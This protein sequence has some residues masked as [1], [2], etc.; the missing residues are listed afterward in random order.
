VGVVVGWVGAG[1]L[2]GRLDAAVLVRV[3]G[4]SGWPCPGNGNGAGAWVY[5]M[6]PFRA[7]PRRGGGGWVTARFLRAVGCGPR[8]PCRCLAALPTGCGCR[9]RVVAP[10]CWPRPRPRTLES[11]LYA[12]T[13]AGRLAG[14][15]GYVDVRHQVT[16][17]TGKVDR[18]AGFRFG[19]WLGAELLQNQSS[20]EADKRGTHSRTYSNAPCGGIWVSGSRHAEE[21]R[22]PAACGSGN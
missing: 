7:R 18:T 12:M 13:F 16:G 9:A 3:V 14:V 15:R 4:C 2:E 5:M 6:V 1:G 21:L 8:A 19:R 17:G 22:Y 10:S 11:R 20:R